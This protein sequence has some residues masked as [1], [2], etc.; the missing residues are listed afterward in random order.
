[1]RIPLILFW[2]TFLVTASLEAQDDQYPPKHYVGEDGK[3]FWNKRLP[4]FLRISETPG[5]QGVLLESEN[6]AYSNPLFLDTEG[7]NYIRTRWAVDNQSGKVVSPAAEVMMPIYADG[8]SPV[9]S[10]SFNNAE[11]SE[12]DGT[13][14]YGPGLQIHISSTDASSGVEFL[15]YKLDSGQWTDFT[16]DLSITGEGEHTLSLYAVDRVGNK[17]ST[18]EFQF[19]VDLQAPTVT[20]NI[21][22][23]ADENVIAPTSK[24]YFTALDDRSGMDIIRYGFDGDDSRI[25]NGSDVDFTYLQDGEHVLEYYAVD[26]VGNLTD[27]SRFAFY[28]DKTAPLTASDILG[29]RFVV[30]KRIYFSGRTKMKL[31]AVD[32]KTGVKE[33]RYSIDGGEFTVYDQPFYLPSIPGEH[34]IRFYSI[35][36]MAN[37]PS[38]SETYKHNVS[39]VYVDLT[40]PDISVRLKGPEFKAAGVQYISPETGIELAGR[41]VE[42]GVQYLSY[43]IDGEAAEKVY[44]QPITIPATGE[45]RIEL[46]AYDNVNNRN[47]DETTVFVDATPPVIY[48]NFST[49]SV[50]EE[51][52]VPLYPPYVTLFLAATDDIVG[53]DRIYYQLNGEPEKLYTR[54][55]GQLKKNEHYS[56]MVRAVDMVGNESTKSFAFKT[57]EN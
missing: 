18:L 3:I 10:A 8:L 43:S 17:E 7:R 33:I 57:S 35:D 11:R 47:L 30:N 27:T 46:F 24:I 52:G 2:M 39:L 38:G 22:G 21:N 13:L 20:H 41:D 53:S 6:P 44:D 56:V 49:A 4:I 55:I 25:Y 51:D 34:Q 31:T 9:S 16:Q 23:L 5:G 15:K 14:Y 36:R 48:E 1:M 28:L 42:S 12:S 40:G 26:K 54:P 50:G 32:N 37:E 45:H 29:D 19:V